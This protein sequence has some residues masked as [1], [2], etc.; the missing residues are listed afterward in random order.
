[1]LPFFNFWDNLSRVYQGMGDMNPITARL[2][3]L[4]LL[5]HIYINNML[6][7]IPLDKNILCKQ[8]LIKNMDNTSFVRFRE[9]SI[10]STNTTQTQSNAV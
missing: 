10:W 3:L 2:T 9:I 6:A 7:T 8:F 4:L 1:M 5:S